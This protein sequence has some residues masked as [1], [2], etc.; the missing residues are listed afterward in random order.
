MKILSF[1]VGIKNLA[2]CVIEVVDKDNKEHEILDWGII[3][4]ANILL[5]GGLKCC[6]AKKGSLC[7]KPAIN[8][9]KIDADTKLGFC[10]LKTCQK[11]LNGTY[12]GKQIKK[13]KQKTTKDL[14]LEQIGMEMYNQLYEKVNL[15]KVDEIVIENQPVL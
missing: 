1:D 2:Y 14:S 13:H 9:V 15:L 4:C 8:R 7:G 3:N 11:E 5:Q 10:K 12:S 6:V